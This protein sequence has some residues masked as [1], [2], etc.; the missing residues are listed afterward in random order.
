MH[1]Q[2]VKIQTEWNLSSR[3]A[4][5]ILHLAKPVP[6]SQTQTERNLS[7]P[8]ILPALHLATPVPDSRN[9]SVLPG[10]VKT[11]KGILSQLDIISGTAS[12]NASTGQTVKTQT[13]RN[14]SQLVII[15]STGQTQQR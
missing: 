13:Q 3:I 9:M 11:E 14:L 12:G 8:G 4:F 6:S 7:Q 1:R 10:R 2:I 5:L 15:S